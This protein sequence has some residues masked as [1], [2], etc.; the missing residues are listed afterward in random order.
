MNSRASFPYRY[1]VVIFLCLL[2]II[3]Y[4]DRISISLV[5]VR[6]KSDFH[7]SNTQFG[8][9]LGAFSLSYALF[10]IPSGIWGDRIGQRA[11]FIRIVLWWSLF[12]AL[13]GMATGFL[14]LLIIRF[15]FGSG[16]AGAVPNTAAAVSRW[17]PMQETSKGLSIAI[18]GQYI[19]SAIGPVIMVPIAQ[20]YGWRSG[21]FVNAVIGVLWVIVCVLWFRNNPSEMKRISE[22]EKIL[23]ETNR[24]FQFH[25]QN[26]HWRK[27]L[28]NRSL[29]ALVIA[30]SASQWSNYFFIA[31]MPLYLQDGKHFSE[32]EMRFTFSSVF[33]IGF[34]A[35]LFSGYLGDW[36]VKRI[37]LKKGRS[38]FGLTVLG[39]LGISILLQTF[40][41]NH[42]TIII[43][44][45]IGIIF[46]ALHGIP[47]FSVC[48]DVAGSRAA[49]VSGIMNFCGQLAAFLI[50]IVF[51]KA[52]D[53]SHGFNVSLYII[54]AA[55][56]VGA[57]L[58]LFVD[59]SKQLVEEN[60]SEYEKA[61]HNH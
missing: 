2:M 55:L 50:V 17:F 47:A 7:L 29:L 59:A 41:A 27:I 56:F 19:G 5:G 45:I 6:I 34:L 39:V 37:G 11:I 4:L 23:I 9:V 60:I 1:R 57:L 48:V 22:Q 10:E 12:T 38:L 18:A 21:F 46:Q 15:L 54:S 35:C 51:G 58:W 33:A 20:A 49:S 40:I 13:T 44:M 3:T 14:S 26:I 31:W 53:F 36:L 32:N 61:E 52:A 25:R 8:M 28:K 43:L 16:E 42:T 30:F 24:R